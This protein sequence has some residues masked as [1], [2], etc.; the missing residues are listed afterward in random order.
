MIRNPIFQREIKGFSRDPKVVFLVLGF[1]VIL[2]AILLLL[3]PAS[4]IFSLASENSLQIFTIFLMSNLALIIL[5]VPA[6]T[7][8]CIT[9]ER[10][11]NSFELLFT[12][13]LTPGEILRGKLLAA[14]ASI[15]L[16]VIV[17]MPI[18]A[19]CA[20]S[21]GIGP[22]LLVRAFMVILMTS[23]CYGVVGLAVS[24]LCRST[25]TSLMITYA[26][27]AGL[28]G[29]T[30]L[31]Y[32]L[33]GRLTM[34][35]WLWLFI[36]TLSPFDALYA[37]LYPARYQLTELTLLSNDPLL[38][39]YV[40]MGGMLV[41]MIIAL[42]IFC[43][44]VLAPPRPGVVFRWLAAFLGVVL[45]AAI[46]AEINLFTAARGAS[47]AV[48]EWASPWKIIGGSIALDFVLFL[49]I[50][51]LWSRSVEQEKYE[52][53][54]TDLKTAVRRKLTWPF[55]LIDPLRRK[56]S[57]GRWRNPVFIA[58]MRGKIFGHPKFIIRG[59]FGCIITSMVLLILICVQYASFLSPDIVRWVAVVFQ[60]GIVAIL[61]PAISSGS[62]TD[63]LT[64]RTFIMLRMTP[65]SA[66]GVVLG[67][68]KAA[69]LYVSIFLV[70]SLP[71]LLSLVY[72]EVSTKELSLFSFWRIGAC[73]LIMI[74]ATL[75]FI[76]AGFCAS[77]FSTNTS[78]A[79]A[80]SYCFAA[81]VCIVSFGAVIPDAFSQG[82]QQVILAI[83]P[84]VAALRVTSDSLFSTMPAN[85][86]LHNVGFLLGISL[87]FIALSAGRVYYI[88]TRQA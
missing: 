31:P 88:F 55:Y 64:S 73:L 41:I 28:A 21:G 69:F 3:W 81:V 71:V 70:S 82:G 67:K 76:T 15:L 43:R 42:V 80:V 74:L 24:A 79:T 35:R 58:E 53:Q 85:I 49:M 25:F 60:I 44:Y 4:G 45:I 29:C 47:A 83:N 32:S 9:A 18:S 39:F 6:L 50:R 72:L 27:I 14:I 68:L 46:G 19:I 86:W 54:Y 52:G 65:I 87:L 22:L 5:L 56:K 48:I 57:I 66:L 23:L 61:A 75:A 78:S 17:S 12:S 34:L 63:E 16:V 8:P 38:P 62:I 20:L 26:L 59:L 11:N 30:W 1:F 40:N 51:G 77:A 10:E 2:S 37:L 7:S 13:L 36:R 84:V 33:F